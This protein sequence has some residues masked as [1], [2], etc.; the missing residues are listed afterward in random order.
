MIST[1]PK[2]RCPGVSVRNLLVEGVSP[3][4]RG[5]Y[6]PDISPPRLFAISFA[7]AAEW[8]VMEALREWRGRKNGRPMI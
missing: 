4:L 8:N 5:W 1:F 3:K 2:V 7:G 6:F